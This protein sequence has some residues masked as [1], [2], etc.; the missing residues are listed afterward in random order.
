M[1]ALGWPDRN[2]GSSS[3]R[4]RKSGLDVCRDALGSVAS[5]TDLS[6]RTGLDDSAGATWIGSQYTV[7]QCNYQAAPTCSTGYNETSAPYWN[8]YQWVGIGCSLPPASPEDPGTQCTAAIPAGFMFGSQAG[9]IPGSWNNPSFAVGAYLSGIPRS[10][11]AYATTLYGPPY[12]EDSCGTTSIN[13]IA[14]CG[15]NPSGWFDQMV[16]VTETGG[17]APAITNAKGMSFR[18]QSPARS[19]RGMDKK[20]AQWAL[21]LWPLRSC[22]R[23]YAPVVNDQV[24]LIGVPSRSPTNEAV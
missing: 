12:T 13:Y 3:L 8:G 14:Y 15:I 23:G 22:Y 19:P 10:D 6:D 11:T 1:P 4:V 24:T 5:G 2:R 17:E 20:S 21:F 7:P 9:F 16:E 18:R